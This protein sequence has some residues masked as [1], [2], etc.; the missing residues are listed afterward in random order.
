[1]STPTPR[2]PKAGPHCH[3]EVAAVA[4][5]LCMASRMKPATPG[6]MAAARNPRQDCRAKVAPKSE[7]SANSVTPVDS[8]PESDVA[9]TL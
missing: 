8:A 5:P 2:T 4:P 6:E 3:D 7:G 9:K 1:M